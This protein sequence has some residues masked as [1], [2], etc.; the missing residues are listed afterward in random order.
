MSR[1]LEPEPQLRLLRQRL[2]YLGIT[3]L[4]W[5][6]SVTSIYYGLECEPY[7]QFSYWGLMS[8]LAVACAIFTMNPRFSQ[9]KFRKYRAAMYAGLRISGVVF[10]EP[11]SLSGNCFS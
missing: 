1:H 8:G 9:P 11:M 4:M 10:T 5:G 3:I 2:D 7:L 6:A